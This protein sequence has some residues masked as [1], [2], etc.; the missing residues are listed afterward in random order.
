MPI[1]PK[2]HGKTYKNKPRLEAV[3]RGKTNIDIVEL[4]KTQDILYFCAKIFANV[5]F[6]LYLCS[7]KDFV[8]NNLNYGS[9]ITTKSGI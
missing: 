6:L 2:C 5:K 8:T 7:R 3:N 9:S 4:P 1:V